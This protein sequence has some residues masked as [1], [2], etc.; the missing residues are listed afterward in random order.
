MC[1]H[2]WVEVNDVAVCTKCGVT[3]VRDGRILFDRRLP[4]VAAKK[5]VVS[6]KKRG[7][8]AKKK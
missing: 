6:K 4:P 7:K 2:Q 3:R 5:K 1:G 8:H